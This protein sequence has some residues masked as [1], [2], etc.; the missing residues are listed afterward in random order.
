[1]LKPLSK[2]GVSNAWV[3]QHQTLLSDEPC[4]WSQDVSPHPCWSPVKYDP[5]G[6]LHECLEVTD[7]VQSVRPDMTGVM[8]VATD[9]VFFTD[10]SRFAP[11]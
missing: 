8:L 1:M 11:Q 6:P 10:G 4:I 3:S 7:L 9:E 5:L 2:A